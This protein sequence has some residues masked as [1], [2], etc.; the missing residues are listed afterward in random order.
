MEITKKPLAFLFINLIPFAKWRLKGSEDNKIQAPLSKKQ[1][2]DVLIEIKN[3]VVQ[4]Q[5]NFILQF[6]VSEASS[7]K[8]KITHPD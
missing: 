3:E 4:A 7:Y 1:I 8:T 2:K 6:L 5:G